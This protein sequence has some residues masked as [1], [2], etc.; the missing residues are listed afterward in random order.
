M[1]CGNCGEAVIFD[2]LQSDRTRSAPGNVQGNL[3]AFGF[4]ISGQWPTLPH[5]VTPDHVPEN[6]ERFFEQGTDSL[7]NGNFDA[8]AMMFRKT[9][10]VSTKERAPDTEKKSLISRIDHLVDAGLLTK[11][12]GSWAHEIRMGGNEAAHDDSVFSREEAE[13]LRSFSESYLRYV[14]T[15]PAMV[16]NRSKRNEGC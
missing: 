16:A 9:L 8:A 5:G 12:I 13:S 14:Y 10:E 2:Y 4:A 6:V 1:R 15:L 3:E 11:E 7:E